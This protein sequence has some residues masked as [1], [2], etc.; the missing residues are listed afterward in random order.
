MAIDGIFS[1]NANVSAICN[2]LLIMLNELLRPVPDLA[3]GTA[4]AGLL[5]ANPQSLF[6]FSE[7]LKG[8]QNSALDPI[9]AACAFHVH[10]GLV[11]WNNQQARFKRV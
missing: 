4:P 9:A 8:T 7:L 6:D 10:K 1:A 2:Q 11:Y 5:D 3:S